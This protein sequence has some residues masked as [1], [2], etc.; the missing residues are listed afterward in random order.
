MEPE[1]LVLDEPTTG[2][3]ESEADEIMAIIKD[4]HQHG[5]TVVMVT[6][7]MEL[8][9]KYAQRVL[10]LANGTLIF[11]GTPEE[12]FSNKPILKQAGLC[13]P[14]SYQIRLLGL[15]I[16]MEYSCIQEEAAG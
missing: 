6:H 9:A 16:S 5:S 15:P 11:T 10:V 14:I 12:V 3:D 13:S 2:Q 7:D 8:V 4:K 1:V